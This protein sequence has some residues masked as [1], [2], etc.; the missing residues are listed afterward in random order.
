MQHVIL[1]IALFISVTLFSQ[2]QNNLQ[3]PEGKT[4]TVTVVNA[5]SDNGDVKFA[6]Y[7]R[8]NFGKLPMLSEAATIEKG[9]STVTFENVPTGFYSVVCYHDENK[10]E[11]MDFYENG[12]PKESF[13]SSNNTWSFGPPQFENSKFEVTK[14]NLT[15]EIKF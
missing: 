6:L 10:N 3:K 2:S 4:I 9:K 14:N 5:L 12:M 11:R 8:E 15:L 1:A 13:G 7:T